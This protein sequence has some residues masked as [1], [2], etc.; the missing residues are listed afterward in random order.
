[1]KRSAVLLLSCG[2]AAATLLLG[3]LA[4]F[5]PQSTGPELRRR[6]SDV[7]VSLRPEDIPEGILPH[8]DGVHQWAVRRPALRVSSENAATYVYAGEEE[9]A[10]YSAPEPA[11]EERHIVAFE[12]SG[13]RLAA[14]GQS[15]AFSGDAQGDFSPLLAMDGVSM[16]A[17]LTNQ[18]RQYGDALDASGRPLR[19]GNAEELVA[20]QNAGSPGAALALLQ[21]ELA[22][23]EVERSVTREGRSG[24]AGNYRQLVEQFAGRFSLSTALVYAII[25]SESN[26]S[27]TLVSNRSAMGLMQILPG[28]A[29]GEIHRFLYGRSG[30][31]G[32]AELSEPEVNIRYG[33]AYLHIL[34]TR[35]FGGVRDPQSRE[36]CA[37]AAYNMGPNRL[38]RFYGPTNEQ[39]VERINA[40][41]SEELYSD[42]VSRLPARE[43]RAYVARVK[44]MKAQYAALR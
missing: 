20:R 36:Y 22:R 38:L 12:A 8:G 13:V 26:F 16:P 4:G 28:T 40:M 35:Y 3:L 27:T 7:V 25:H 14:G 39:A 15:L 41:T 31:V 1:M 33:T 30:T 43:T 37:V 17:L 11:P 32:F 9:Y 6:A 23:R 21:R 5:V 18:P 42:L 24:S 29:G 19:W 34:H 10:L 2:L 44:Q